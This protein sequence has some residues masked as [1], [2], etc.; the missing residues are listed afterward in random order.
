[1]KKRIIPA[2]LAAVVALSAVAPS[3][4]YSGETEAMEF[5]TE[6]S[7]KD[8]EKQET[9]QPDFQSPDEKDGDTVLDE[10]GQS[11]T[12]TE[13]SVPEEV[14]DQPEDER[15]DADEAMENPEEQG[16]TEPE[17]EKTQES[18]ETEPEEEDPGVPDTATEAAESGLPDMEILFSGESPADTQTDKSEEQP[19]ETEIPD[20]DNDPADVQ[21]GDFFRILVQNDET[22]HVSVIFL[23]DLEKLKN[24]TLETEDPLETPEDA[25]KDSGVYV[26]RV[27]TPEMYGLDSGTETGYMEAGAE[28]SGRSIEMW[29]DQEAGL[30]T[31]DF[32]DYEEEAAEEKPETDIEIAKEILPADVSEL[33]TEETWEMLKGQVHELREGDTAKFY[34]I[35]SPGYTVGE[36]NVQGENGRMDIAETAPGIYEF[37]MPKSDVVMEIHAEKTEAEKTEENTE[38]QPVLPLMAAAQ[39]SGIKVQKVNADTKMKQDY[40]FTYAFREGVTTLKSISRYNGTLNEKLHGWFGDENGFTSSYCNTFYGALINDSTYSSPI[41]VLYSNVG[42]YQG[43]IVDLK[44]TAV[45]WGTVNNNHVG[46]D[47]N[48]IY[49]CILFYKDRIAFNTISVGTVRFQ[50]EFY[51]HNTQ[52]KISPKGHVTM[53]DLDGGQGFRIYDNWGVD[54]LYI[55]NG[56]DHLKASAGTSSG[57]SSYLEL[58]GEEGVATTNSD[59]KGWCQVDFNGTFTV[60]WMAQ[61]SWSTGKGPMNAFFISTSRSVGT[62]EPNPG[63]TKK[64]GDTG[65]SFDKMQECGSENNAF[66]IT[67]GKTFD[68]VIS[69]RLLPGDYSKFEVTDTLDSCLTY[70]SAKVQTSGGQDVTKYFTV[71]YSGNTVKFSAQPAFLKTDEAMNDVTYYFRIQV[72]ARD[73]GT[74]A[75]HNHYKESVFYIGNSAKRQIV[76]SMLNDTQSTNVTYVKGKITG[77]CFVRKVDGEDASQNLTGAEFDL[78]QWSKGKNQYVFVKKMAYDAGKKQYGSGIMTYTSDNLGKFRIVESKAPQGYDGGWQRDVDLTSLKENTVYE[79]PN[80]KIKI[81]YGRIYITKKDSLTGKEIEEKDGAFKVLQWNAATETYEDTLETPDITYHT[82]EGAYLSE[83]LPVTEEN[84]GKFR[85]VEVKNPS[86]YEGTFEKEISFA[87]AVEQEQKIEIEAANTPVLPPMGKI[88]VVKQIKED[89]ITWAHGNPVFRFKVSGTDVKGKTHTYEDYVEFREGEY[90]TENGYGIMKCVFEI[91]LGRYTVSELET[92][93]YELEGVYADT[94]NVS[95]SGNSGIAA[96]DTERPEAELTFRNRKTIYDRYSHTDVIRNKIPIIP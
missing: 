28:F 33:L 80:T 50:F 14:T 67:P 78:Y 21:S 88:T 85:I 58:R 83:R 35:P 40:A 47:G 22:D 90:T 30:I 23:S 2:V 63:S 45:S 5:Q 24:G 61:K 38:I 57:G 19:P 93:R 70:R 8:M 73:A 60:N 52:E 43:Q 16:E 51:K 34:V 64:V 62:Y 20:P 31:D 76:S 92:L 94:E 86:G 82:E 46:L 12:D 26:T 39:R 42:E 66:E 79:A 9:V 69:Q 41:S 91:P 18:E 36:V 56:Y 72:T 7:G 10:S 37:S 13:P 44:V 3:P 65:A 89:E 55:R 4:V 1:M 54:G 95:V 68:Y 53:A 71:S 6:D 75:A 77:S 48:R 74:I 11:G 81:S 29:T 17:E 59:P 32:T 27:C 25:A 96:I 49:P 15:T 84:E 87:S